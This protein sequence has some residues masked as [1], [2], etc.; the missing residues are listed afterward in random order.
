MSISYDQKTWYNGEEG[1]TPI[2]ASELNRMEQGIADAVEAINEGG[3]GQGGGAHTNLDN[4]ANTTTNSNTIIASKQGKSEL[5]SKFCYVENNKFVS[6]SVGKTYISQDG[7]NWEEQNNNLSSIIANDS[8]AAFKM[9]KH[10]TIY[11]AVILT[12]SLRVFLC[13]SYDLLNWTKSLIVGGDLDHNTNGYEIDINC[14]WY[15]NDNVCVPFNI[16]NNCSLLFVPLIYNDDTTTYPPTRCLTSQNGT[17]WSVATT[18]PSDFADT[19]GYKLYNAVCDSSTN[20]R[21]LIAKGNHENPIEVWANT[22]TTPTTFTKISEITLENEDE[23]SG[24]RFYEC[25]GKYYIQC[26]NGGICCSNDLINWSYKSCDYLGRL[27]GFNNGFMLLY[28]YSPCSLTY[29]KANSSGEYPCDSTRQAV[30]GIEGCGIIDLPTLNE[31][32]WMSTDEICSNGSGNV[33]LNVQYLIDTLNNLTNV[34]NIKLFTATPFVNEV[35]LAANILGLGS[36]SS[37]GGSG[38]S[39]YSDLT[40]KPSINGVELLGNKT[41]GLLSTN[42][43][44]NADKIGY[45]GTVSGAN[46]AKAAIESLKSS[47]D[48]ISVDADDVSYDNTTSGMSATNVQDAIDEVVDDMSHIDVNVCDLSK[49]TGKKL[50]IAHR[51]ASYECPEQSL[52]AYNWAGKF[53]FDGAECDVQFTSDNVPILMHDSTV[54][55]TTNGSGTVASLT[56]SQITALKIDYAENASGLTYYPNEK[57][58]T[59][60]QYLKVCKYWGMFPVI[61]I[62]EVDLT[63]A[64]AQIIVDLVVKYGLLEDAIFIGWGQNNLLN[65]M[66]VDARCK[67]MPLIDITQANVDWCVEHKMIGIDCDYTTNLTQSKVQLCHDNGLL[68]GMWTINDTTNAMT[69]NDYGVDMQTSNSIEFAFDCDNKP[70]WCDYDVSETHGITPTNEYEWECLALGKY[71]KRVYNGNA[72]VYE[73]D[74]LPQADKPRAILC[75]KFNISKNIKF[76]Y[77]FPSTTRVTNVTMHGFYKDTDNTIKAEDIGWFT[78]N[79]TDLYGVSKTYTQNVSEGIIYIG[80]PQPTNALTYLELEKLYK[81]QIIS[82]VNEQPKITASTTDITAGSTAL[83]TGDIYVVYE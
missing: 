3:G 17:S 82:V 5:R 15:A 63:I 45:S 22:T 52:A 68:V 76:S 75:K 42:I 66:S 9:S 59:L 58:P 12:S 37:G 50:M 49:F 79:K 34:N 53:K 4:I 70:S 16:N 64:K 11:V 13:Y 74:T 54:D 61:E 41:V 35:S 60:E 24:G 14:S 46:T 30:V 44:I 31:G 8:I 32:S 47:I 20:Y 23:F 19:M 10:S 78:T 29:L 39:D 27:V 18:T 33:E 56:A 65:L 77:S 81:D 80:I 40:N 38:T 36:G 72:N 26:E 57:V 67:C 21:I 43:Q 28:K 7:A 25:N 55:R 71:L 83:A 73:Y 69:C 1:G 62:K 6:L 51:G 2:T 48:N